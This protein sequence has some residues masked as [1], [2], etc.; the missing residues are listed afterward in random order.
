MVCISLVCTGPTAFIKSF[1][2]F[3]RRL[4]KDLK[5][6]LEGVGLSKICRSPVACAKF[7][8]KFCG[9]FVVRGVTEMALSPDI[10]EEGN[11]DG[12]RANAKLAGPPD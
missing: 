2:G 1:L 9:D 5:G 12:P 6:F 7:I 11:S 4:T 10:S 8:D 3:C